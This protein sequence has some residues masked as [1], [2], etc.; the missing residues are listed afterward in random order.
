MS[1]RSKSKSSK[2]IETISDQKIDFANRSGTSK[3]IEVV[4][5]TIQCLIDGEDKLLTHLCVYWSRVVATTFKRLSFAKLIMSSAS[6][7]RNL[8]SGTVHD[9]FG[10]VCGLN[11]VTNRLM[12]Q[13]KLLTWLQ[14]A[15]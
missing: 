4:S 12:S 5:H 10:C 14:F 11:D 13:L 7:H 8:S 6:Q 1:H 2:L 9:Q 15:S 3:L